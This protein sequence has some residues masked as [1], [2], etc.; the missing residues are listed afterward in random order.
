MLNKL[1]QV[2]NK[3]PLWVFILGLTL[4]LG[5]LAF[6]SSAG[7]SLTVDE[8]PHIVAGYS[9]V[10]EGDYRLNPEHPPLLKLLSG[11]SIWLGDKL[12]SQNIYFPNN[13][14]AWNE[15]VNA[16]WD[17][18]YELLFQSGNDADT[19]IWWARLPTILILLL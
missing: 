2:Y 4:I 16:Q 19:I 17:M 5:V 10:V 12:T 15:K 9:Y 13:I 6:G 18:G 8:S 11:I 7:D 14:P 3:T 1:L